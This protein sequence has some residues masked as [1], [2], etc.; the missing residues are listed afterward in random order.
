M[1]IRDRRI[2]RRRIRIRSRGWLRGGIRIR[3][4]IW[5]GDLEAELNLLASMGAVNLDMDLASR[6]GLGPDQYCDC[7]L[8][9]GTGIEGRMATLQVVALRCA[10]PTVPAISDQVDESGEEMADGDLGRILAGVGDPDP[11]GALATSFEDPGSGLDRQ[12]IDARGRHRRERGQ[13][14]RHLDHDRQQTP[15]SN[16]H[17]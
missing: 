17:G 8:G 3:S 13:Y 1:R 2:R 15:G 6:R 12:G 16:R 7:H 9:D 10:G 5:V 4:W 14:H 11:V